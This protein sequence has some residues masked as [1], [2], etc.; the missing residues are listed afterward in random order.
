MSIDTLAV[1]LLRLEV[2]Q[3]LSPLQITE[4]TRR[5]EKMVYKPGQL[6]IKDGEP[7]DAAVLIIAGEAVRTKG[8]PE[9]ADAEAIEPGSLLGEMAMLIETDYSSTV[10]AIGSVRALRITRD[11]MLEM[12]LEDR[13]LAEHFVQ[14]ISRRLSRLA[15]ELRQIDATLAGIDRGYDDAADGPDALETSDLDGI[16]G[17]AN[18]RSTNDWA[19]SNR[20]L[21]EAHDHPGRIGY[22]PT[23]PPS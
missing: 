12:M 9:A 6:L 5:A 13:S 20:N 17:S 7:G 4:I 15:I 8:Q 18:V 22:S 11:A 23:P 16:A 21:G 10:V 14:K 3:D 19:S 2:F 1:H